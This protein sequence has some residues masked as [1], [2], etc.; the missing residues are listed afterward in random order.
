MIALIQLAI[1]VASIK[2]ARSAEDCSGSEMAPAMPERRFYELLSEAAARMQIDL[3]VFSPA[4]FDHRTAQLNGYRFRSGKWALEPCALPDIVY[5]RSFCRS[6][7]EQADCRASLAALRRL[8]PYLSLNGSLPSKWI[9]YNTLLDDSIIAPALPPTRLIERPDELMPMLKAASSAGL[10][11]KPSAGMQG[12]GVIHVRRN[13]LADQWLVTGRTGSNRRFEHQFDSHERLERWTAKA[14]GGAAY[15]SQPCLSLRSRCGS[16]FDVRV[17]LQKNE[18]GRWTVSG[19]AARVGEPGSLT[20]NLHGGG[21]PANAASYLANEFGRRQA[22]RLLSRMEQLSLYAAPKLE[23]RF[24]RLA[25]LG[26]D[27]GIEPDGRLWLLEV[28]SRPGRSAFRQIGDRQAERHSIEQPLRYAR[29]LSKRMRPLI[30]TNPQASRSYDSH[31]R[32]RTDYVQEVH[33]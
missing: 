21:K 12:K 13:P 10:F 16:P 19:A 31:R 4:E 6:N 11:L 25:E 9:V 27:Y 18:H 29:L 2:A 28:N 23:E 5:D 14:V 22:E 33:P 24:G 1:F 3:F 32:F 8:K 7:E 17:L 30:I 26:F 20:S 15:L